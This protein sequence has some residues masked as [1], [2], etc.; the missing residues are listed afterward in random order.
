MPCSSAGMSVNGFVPSSSAGLVFFGLKPFNERASKGLS[1]DAIAAALNQKLSS[2]QDGMI[3]V[4]PAP[5]VMG[6]GTLGGFKLQIEDRGEAGA[7]RR[8]TTRRRTC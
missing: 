5:P 3:V 7:R 6:L 1:A 4:F 2:I 8:S